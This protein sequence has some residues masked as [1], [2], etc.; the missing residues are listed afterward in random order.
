MGPWTTCD[1]VE[2]QAAV[3]FCLVVLGSVWAPA[4]LEQRLKQPDAHVD[5]AAAP[6]ADILGGGFPRAG[7]SATE[8]PA[9][10]P[11]ALPAAFVYYRHRG[12]THTKDGRPG[13][14]LG[15]GRGYLFDGLPLGGAAGAEEAV[16][17]ADEVLAQL[18]QRLLAPVG[19]GRS[20]GRVGGHRQQPQE[21]QHVGGRERLLPAALQGASGHVQQG[22]GLGQAAGAGHGL[23]Q[24]RL[25]G[26][27]GPQLQRGRHTAA[28]VTAVA[29]ARTWLWLDSLISWPMNGVGPDLRAAPT[30]TLFP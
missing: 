15:G 4:T 19:A 5:A 9:P 11:A 16:G 29:G 17:H 6:A 18:P 22:G 13:A 26:D 30:C 24:S 3:G 25:G 23:A 12:N 14:R 20:G 27:T 1:T 21:R 7:G 8:P 28:I 2:R 10:E